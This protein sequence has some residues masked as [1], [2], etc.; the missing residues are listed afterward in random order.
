MN[1]AIV[2]TN[3]VL[4][5]HDACC[6][7]VN[8]DDSVDQLKLA[9]AWNQIELAKTDIFRDDVKWQVC[10]IFRFTFYLEWKFHNLVL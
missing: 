2:I 1:W 9:L 6:F 8:D 3:A 4:L 10:E 5:S 7:T